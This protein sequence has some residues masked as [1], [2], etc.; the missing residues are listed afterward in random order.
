MQKNSE[1]GMKHCKV[2]TREWEERARERLLP[3]RVFFDASSSPSTKICRL[4]CYREI[5]PSRRSFEFYVDGRLF[6]LTFS[7]VRRPWIYI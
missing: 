1:D 7:L 4:R 3:R 6:D 2:S 5:V